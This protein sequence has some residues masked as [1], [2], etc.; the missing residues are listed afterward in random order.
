MSK[1]YKWL[2]NITGDGERDKLLLLGLLLTDL[3]WEGCKRGDISCF[4]QAVHRFLAAMTIFQYLQKKQ[5][6][7]I[8]MVICR[9]FQ[10]QNPLHK[11]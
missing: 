2:F 5:G 7:G 1:K 9:W 11:S 3:P 6:I 10:K 4:E 8:L